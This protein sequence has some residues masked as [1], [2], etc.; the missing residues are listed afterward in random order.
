MLDE[1]TH[2]SNNLLHPAL[3][4]FQGPALLSYNNAIFTD[5]DFGNLSRLGDSD[6]IEDGSKTGRF[7]RGF[8]S[9]SLYPSSGN[10]S[11]I[12]GLQLD[13]FALNHLAQSTAYLGAS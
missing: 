2:E 1:R 13:W 4:E 10:I 8:N 9:V 7:G 3:G 12:P 11:D 6:K 5:N